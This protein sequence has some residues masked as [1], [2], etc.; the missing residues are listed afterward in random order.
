MDNLVIEGEPDVTDYVV[1]TNAYDE[2][3]AASS[4]AAER[5][6]PPTQIRG[7]IWIAQLDTDLCTELLDASDRRGEN[8]L[9]HR[10]FHCS[11]AFYRTNAPAGPG[12]ELHFDADGALSSCIALSRIVHPTAVGFEHALRIR[13][14]GNSAREIIP[15]YIENLNAYAFVMDPSENWLIRSD[16]AILRMLIEAVQA[17]PPQD[18][19]ASALWYH[20]AVSRHYFIDLRWPLLTTCLESLVRIKDE[21]LP[22]NRHAGSTKVFVDR[23]HAIGNLEPALAVPESELRLMYEERSLLTHGL[24]FVAL[25]EPRKALYRTQERLARGI[26]RK[27]LLEPKFRALFASDA[28]LAAGLPLRP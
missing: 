21:R 7:D 19:L 25:D 6:D 24:S 13:R 14:R 23:L 9:S 2:S 26:I 8:W 27:V 1:V 11:Y 4:R 10:Q 12:H 28:A 20:E 5:F 15:A 16:I 22:N 18:R 3:N 17:N